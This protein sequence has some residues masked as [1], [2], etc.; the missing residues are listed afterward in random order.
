MTHPYSDYKVSQLKKVI[1]VACTTFLTADAYVTTDEFGGWAAPK[2]RDVQEHLDHI[3]EM[4]NTF[5]FV[6]GPNG[7][8]VRG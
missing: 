8:L 1:N 4:C 7:F 6:P 3:N 5:G 2:G